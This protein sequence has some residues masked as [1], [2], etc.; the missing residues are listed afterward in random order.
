MWYYAEDDYDYD[1]Y[2]FYDDSGYDYGLLE[3]NEY[4]YYNSHPDEVVDPMAPTHYE[5][6]AN[7]AGYMEY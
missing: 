6:M 5:V 4:D 3:Y 2:D 7:A 1:Y